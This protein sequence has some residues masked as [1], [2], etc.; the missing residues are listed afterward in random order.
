MTFD[1][2][3]DQLLKHEGGYVWHED[4]PGGET[5]MG[6]SKR[7]YP[8]LDIR[9]LTRDQARAIYLRDFWSPAGC[10]A[11]PPGVRGQVFDMAVHSGVKVAVRTLQQACGATQDG[12]LGPR[13]LQAVLNMPA[14]RVAARFCGARL[15]LL[16]GLPTWPEFGRGWARRMAANL[17]EA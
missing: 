17:M 1:E 2:A 5:N 11:L 15:R 12:I 3:L 7:S 13:T 16:T 14:A 9:N 6:I 10:D 8:Q 4:D